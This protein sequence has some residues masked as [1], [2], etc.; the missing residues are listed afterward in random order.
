MDLRSNLEVL[1]DEKRKRKEEN[2]KIHSQTKKKERK[3]KE[4]VRVQRSRRSMTE[5][6]C[7]L[8]LMVTKTKFQ[9]WRNLPHPR[10]RFAK[11]QRLFFH[12][13]CTARKITQ[14]R[15][16]HTVTKVSGKYCKF[17]IHQLA[18]TPRSRFHTECTA[19]NRC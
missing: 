13:V 10:V 15:K 16:T 2:V 17:N 1:E 9:R 8:G 6:E 19:N 12:T 5:C 14:N 18:K 11:V 3:I 4:Q 7:F